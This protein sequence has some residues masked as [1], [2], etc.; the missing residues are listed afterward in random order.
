LSGD[1][2]NIFD[3]IYVFSVLL[4]CKQEGNRRLN[5]NKGRMEERMIKM[6]SELLTARVSA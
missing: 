1:E 4:S 6:Y 5:K 2:L 3:H